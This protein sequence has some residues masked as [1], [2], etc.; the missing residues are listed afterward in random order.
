M[1]SGTQS[2]QIILNLENFPFFVGVV[3]PNTATEL[4]S[5]L[6]FALLIDPKLAVPRLNLTPQIMDALDKAYGASSMLS[7]PLGESDLANY[8]MIEMLEKLKSIY[9]DDFKAKSFLEI[10]CG[11]GLL[12]N[13]VKQLGALVSGCEVGPQGKTAS[14]K[15]DFQVVEPPLKASQFDAKFDC[16]FSYGCL[17]HVV[18]LEELFKSCRDILNEGGLFFHCVPNMDSSYTSKRLDELCHEH[19]NYFTP[20]NSTRLL[21]CQGFSS[22][23]SHLTTAGNE[24]FFWGYRDASKP[25]SWPGETETVLETETRKLTEFSYAIKSEVNHLSSSLER[26]Y[27]RDE[28]IGFYGGGVSLALLMPSIENVRFYDGDTSKHGKCWLNTLPP[29]QSP[30]DLKSDPVDNLIIC[31]EHHYSKII[32]YLTNDIDIPESI[33]IIKLSEI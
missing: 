30:R 11:N 16:I 18:D 23:D 24:F 14:E 5:K 27:Q 15:Y 7:T 33:K 31:P 6:P 3:D 20:R 28:S 8:R 13:A 21:S 4:P 29:I 1:T 19:I 2:Q 10:G 12:L 25:L 32:N 26:I 17:E 22:V 9:G